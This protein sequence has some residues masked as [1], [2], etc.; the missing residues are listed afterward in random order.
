M[1]KIIITENQFKTVIDKFIN[2]A[3]YGSP[4]EE[5]DEIEYNVNKSFSSGQYKIKDSNEIDSAILD[6]QKRMSPNGSYVIEIISSES[7]V[8]NRGGLKPGELSLKRA[9]E[10]KRYI[11]SK[12][13]NNIQTKVT[14]LGAQGPEW[15]PSKGAFF[16][17]YTDNQYVR[18]K[19]LGSSPKDN[20]CLVDLQ[21]I[22]DY[23]GSQGVTYPYHQCDEAL[24]KMF[25][26]GV[27]VKLDGGGGDFINLNNQSDGGPRIVNLKISGDDVS[28]ILKTQKDKINFTLQCFT[29]TEGG[30]HSDPLHVTIKN[31]QGKIL[32]N[33]TFITIGKRMKFGQWLNLM[34]T[35]SCGVPISYNKASNAEIQNPD[36]KFL[37]D[38]RKSKEKIKLVSSDKEGE[39]YTSESLSQIYSLV[40]NGIVRIPKDSIQKYEQRISSLNN[41]PWSSIVDS[42]TISDKQ[43]KEI[44]NIT[45]NLKSNQNMIATK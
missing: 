34:V 37:T 32:L 19:L 43:M 42:W 9:E 33:P 30:C 38:Y 25:A 7:K 44:E 2:E 5:R 27:P 24:F 8:P 11:D 45:K 6:F 1:R 41:K 17:G 22:V 28:Q 16:Q 26:N 13:L 40:D 31:N 20:P 14:S 21:I 3:T 10:I 36:E 23:K 29:D 39:Y 18:L 15:E 35:D 12:G 4:K